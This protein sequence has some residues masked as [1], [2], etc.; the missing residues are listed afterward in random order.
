MTAPRTRRPAVEPPPETQSVILIRHA[1]AAERG[2]DYPD[3]DVR[4]LTKRGRK[5]MAQAARGLCAL[6]PRFDVVI[7]S[8]LTRARQTA[9]ILADVLGDEWEAPLTIVE[10]AALAPGGRPEQVAASCLEP[11]ADPPR[12]RPARGAVALVGHEPDLGGLAAWLIGARESL[13]FKKGGMARIDVTS[14]VSAGCGRLVWFASP[15]MLRAIGA[16]KQ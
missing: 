6:G 1:I 11:G 14:P 7:S 2:D 4:P 3:D 12:S 15:K 8:P 5:R 16:I 10:C 9:D 13:P